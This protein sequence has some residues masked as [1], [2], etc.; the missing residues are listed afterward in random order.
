MDL[1]RRNEPV[2]V[3]RDLLSR[4]PPIPE[5]RI[6]DLTPDLS[7]L[8]KRASSDSDKQTSGGSDTTPIV[9][10]VVVPVI[11]IAIILFV[12]WRRR[13]NITKQEKANDKYKS[14]D[15]GVDPSLV[16]EK[17]GRKAQKNVA[18]MT[19]AD[20]KDTL[21]KDRGASLDL[22]TMN[23]YL[24]PPEVQQSR[25]SL[26]SLSR[27]MTADGDKYR[28]TT[29]V[30]DDGSM[31]SPSIRS[32]EDGSSIFSGSTRHRAGTMDTDSKQDLLPRVPP[33][34]EGSEAPSIRKPMPTAEKA[35]TGLL[36]PQLPV[37]RNSTLSTASTNQNVAAFR[38]SNNYLGQFISGG[39]K[40]EPKKEEAKKNEQPG[41]IVSAAEIQ[42]TPP[43]DEP[44]EL[45]AA[46]TYNELVTKKRQSSFYGSTHGAAEL[47]DSRYDSTHTSQQEPSLPQIETTSYEME[48]SSKSQFPKR[49]QSRRDPNHH[50]PQAHD[51][52]AQHPPVPEIYSSHQDQQQPQ[53]YDED[54]YDEDFQDYADYIGYSNRGSMMGTRPLPPDDP[55]ENPEQRANRIRSFYKEYFDDSG[56]AAKAGANYYDGSE[57]YDDFDYGYYEQSH[58]RGPS[59]RSDGRQRAFS[60]GNHSYYAG[61]RAYSSMSG[62][63]AH[64]RPPPKKKL[65]PPKPLMV[66]PTPHKL[67]D[68][69]FLPNAIDYAPPSVFKNQRSGT[70]DSLRGGLRP[71]SPSV[72]PHV[73]LTSSFDDLAVIPSPHSL[74]RSGTFTA[75]DFA[76]PRRFTEQGD[77]MSDSGSVR[78][79]RSNLSK[80]HLANIR[81]GAYRVSRIPTDVAGTRSDMAA[82]LRPK[83]DMRGD[84]AST[85]VMGVR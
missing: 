44:R 82:A 83:W 57:Q 71:Y 5:L 53:D 49:T 78:S 10:G 72:R 79:N 34:R 61:P 33:K 75:L 13:V 23:P 84:G 38:A 76:P 47:A 19:I 15:F 37:D 68:D 1:F 46:A 22:G 6:R 31:R 63:V 21:R 48:D 7:S 8:Q 28:A 45:P 69:D 58:S 43:V 29:F 24:L 73:P 80:M 36:A 51:M 32:R 30:P 81:N 18:E 4:P 35:Q 56:N 11:I 14:L 52:I 25:E 26:H 20:V 60:H 66:L 85:P 50:N 55:S 54:Y 40:D 17:K 74:R 59:I 67:K 12:I 65:P 27:T 16:R 70:P 64:R 41:L 2:L 3:N 39:K 42:V 62:Q 77:S 9:I